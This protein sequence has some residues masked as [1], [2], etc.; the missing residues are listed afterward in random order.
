MLWRRDHE[1][2]SIEKVAFTSEPFADV[3]AYVCLPQ[4]AQPP[5]PFMIC[6]Q[7]HSTGMHNSIAVQRDDECKPHEVAGDRDFA[8]TCMRHG[9][10][11]LCI[12]Q[13]SFGLRREQKQRN[14]MPP[15][16]AT[17][18]PCTP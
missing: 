4:T 9:I 7:G 16:A 6:L 3:V 15:T 2:G 5:Y 18:P 13:R 14:I 11:A 10:A 1:L 8:L 12:E 17:T